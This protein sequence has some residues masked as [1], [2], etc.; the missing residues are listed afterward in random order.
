MLSIIRVQGNQAVATY[1]VAAANRL[2]LRSDAWCQNDTTCPFHAQGKGS[3]P[4]VG[5]SSSFIANTAAK[6]EC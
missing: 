6:P 1:Q 5:L 2:L 3:I 4:K